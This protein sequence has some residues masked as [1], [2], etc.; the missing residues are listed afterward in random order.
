MLNRV[1]IDNIEQINE[2]Q[3]IFNVVF[4]QKNELINTLTNSPYVHLYTYCVDKNIV[5]FIEFSIMYDRCE[6]D[7]IY[8][9]ELYRKKGIASL[10]LEFMIEVC[11][12]N[13]TKNITLEVREDNNPAI[14]LYQKYGFQKKAIRHNY[15]GDCNG[16]LMEKEM[17]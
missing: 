17:V 5:A 9:L 14:Q 13:K 12:N 11:K 1:T 3:S 2:L 15:Y 7:N 10:L 6:L 16:I 4:K 8:V